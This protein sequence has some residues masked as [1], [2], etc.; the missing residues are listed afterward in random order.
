MYAIRLSAHR[1]WTRISPGRL[2]AS[3]AAYA[4]AAVL[5][6]WPL[7]RHL[8]TKLMGPPDS[9]LGVYV[10]NLWVFRHEILAGHS[11]LF[12]SS[13][14]SL[15][16]PANLAQHNYTI[17]SD[18]LAVPLLSVFGLV[19]SYNIVVLLNM[20]AASAA[21]F[22]LAFHV[23]RR[24]AIAWLAGLLFGFSPMLMARAE[25]HPS[26]AAAAPLPL[27]VFI[28]LRVDATRS[29]RWAAAGG[30]TLAW[31]AVCDPYYVIYCGLLAAWYLWTRTVEVRH[32]PWRWQSSR[33]T[34]RV[35]D[36]AIVGL[37]FVTSAILATGGTQFTL[38]A[39]RVGLTT[40]YT[41]NLLLMAAVLLRVWMTL[42]PRL[43]FRPGSRWVE[44]ARLMSYTG[45]A[46]AVL[47]SPVLYAIAIRW[48]DGAYVATPLPWRTSTPGADLMTM[49]MPSPN[50]PWLGVPWRAWLEGQ[51][52]GYA[53][54]VTSITLVATA[55][56]IAATA[57]ASFRIPRFWGGLALLGG[58]LTVGPFIRVAGIDT[59][60]PMPWAVLR[61]APVVSIARAPA[62][63]AVLLVLAAAVLFA[64]ALAAL[65]DRRPALRRPLLA[66]VGLLLAFELCP[67]PR[68]L[69][70]GTIAPVYARIAAD[71]RDVRVLE[72]PFGVRDGLSSF[73]DF[74]AASQFH[75]TLHG[76]RLIGGYLS[77]VS[78]R[79]FEMIKRRPVLA[80]LA[81]L[82]EGRGVT[83][84]EREAAK[85]RGPGFVT[86]ARLGYVVVDRSRASQD[87]VDVATSTLDLEKI[88]ESGSRELYRPRA[89][90][91]VT[92]SVS[93]PGRTAPLNPPPAGRPGGQQ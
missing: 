51:P 79:R 69:H 44:L 13:I 54:N 58:C 31:A 81:A 2:A 73:G 17:F 6:T 21:M 87:L 55:V 66:G 8:S 16:G 65:A 91:S 34:I 50:N 15:D 32:S 19:A 9:D 47:L 86:A 77:R 38:G 68:P 37:L 59:Y 88:G 41:P 90:V 28:L 72:L 64:L 35:V 49:F 78:S 61:Y 85:R 46:G 25:I 5:F 22:L 83:P 14:F 89:P 40:V 36:G 23:V 10:W 7:V 63:F 39:W 33:V 82:S 76:K 20:V 70:D 93:A 84:A 27:F 80:V 75:Q 24:P 18:I 43:E 45:V 26:L 67:A 3:V 29:A 4:A 11:P 56:I 62:R 42:R 60:L 12:T 48:F 92:A 1:Q 30:V 52:G 74:S 53:E 57:F 71:P